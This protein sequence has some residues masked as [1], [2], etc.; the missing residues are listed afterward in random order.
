[1]P[2]SDSNGGG[3]SNYSYVQDLHARQK[4]FKRLAS[5]ATDVVSQLALAT[6]AVVELRIAP[7]EGDFVSEDGSDGAFVVYSGE[8]HQPWTESARRLPITKKSHRLMAYR[9]TFMWRQHGMNEGQDPILPLLR[10]VKQGPKTPVKKQRTSKP[11]TQEAEEEAEP[12]AKSMALA[13]DSVQECI[14][15]ILPDVEAS[16][17]IRADIDSVQREL[18]RLRET[19]A[20]IPRERAQ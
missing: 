12:M 20:A 17:S 16:M 5:K 2:R 1:M 10:R 15:A 13:H 3:S 8:R 14:S 18:N 11:T 9:G 7:P 4:D 6:G 19:M